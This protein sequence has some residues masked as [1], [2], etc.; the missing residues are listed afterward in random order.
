MTL[1]LDL[2]SW[3]GAND[4]MS[5]TSTHKCSTCVQRAWRL[6]TKLVDAS[7]HHHH[8]PH[9]ILLL[10]VLSLIR[11]GG[12][13]RCHGGSYDQNI[14]TCSNYWPAGDCHRSRLTRG[15]ALNFFSNSF[16]L[17]MSNL[18][19]FD[20][21]RE[22]HGLSN[23]LREIYRSRRCLYDTVQYW[24]GWLL[25]LECLLAWTRYRLDIVHSK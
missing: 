8:H 24:I 14:T 5:R 2:V 10:R 4:A 6:K 7:S 23:V 9:T 20:A 11:Q 18:H 15:F 3:K 13:W 12:N 25:P 22:L 16:L 19:P 21:S 1:L 17:Q